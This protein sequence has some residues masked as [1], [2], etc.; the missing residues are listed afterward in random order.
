MTTRAAPKTRL[1]LRAASLVVDGTVTRPLRFAGSA[2]DALLTALHEAMLKRG[3]LRDRAHKGHCLNCALLPRCAVWPLVAPAD[4]TRR[5]RGAY[6]R[7]WVPLLP[8]LPPVVSVGVPVTYGLTVVQD[9]TFPALWGA[10]AVAFVGAAR[11]LAEWGVGDLVAAP[12]TPAR[13]GALS[14]GRVRWRHPIT[15]ESQPFVYAEGEPV[16]PPFWYEGGSAACRVPSAEL[17]R[18]TPET[19]ITPSI[20]GDPESALGTR[21]SA[22][23]TVAFVTPTRLVV[24]GATRQTPDCATLVRRIAERVETLCAGLLIS[25]P[26]DLHPAAAIAAAA[27]VRVATDATRWEGGE[28]RGGIRGTVTYTGAADDLALTLPALR[29]GQVLGVGKGAQ[30]GAGRLEV[31]SAK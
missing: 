4:P 2:G 27:R 9:G 28:K 6:V 13:R 7:P 21:H 8:D 20:G 29:W 24:A 3:C 26:D 5:Q 25:P 11:Q 1:P 18:E 30:S 12:G 22:L 10:F 23:L 31:L 19:N 14:V 16:A 17:T 15:G